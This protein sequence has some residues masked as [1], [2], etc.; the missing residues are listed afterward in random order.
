MHAIHYYYWNQLM[1]IIDFIENE[2]DFHPRWTVNYS[3]TLKSGY[4]K[5]D[6]GENTLGAEGTFWISK[7][8]K[9]E[10]VATCLEQFLV[11]YSQYKKLEQNVLR[12]IRP[13]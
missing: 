5:I 11:W 3:V 2:A 1:E 8:A 7:N 6:F 10:A 13:V 12:A 9:R 4:C